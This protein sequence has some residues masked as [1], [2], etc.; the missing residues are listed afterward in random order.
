M[1]V[2]A[3]SQAFATT[4]LQPVQLWHDARVWLTCAA[5]A[6]D[7]ESVLLATSCHAAGLVAHYSATGLRAGG[8][9]A[10]WYCF[11]GDS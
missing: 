7:I 6:A 10:A 4:D 1:P 9:G 5:A 2:P 3:V 11:V 8:S